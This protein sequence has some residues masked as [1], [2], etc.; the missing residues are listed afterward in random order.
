VPFA[1]LLRDA[2]ESGERQLRII[3]DNRSF[4]GELMGLTKLVER[5]RREP[6]PLQRERR[7]RRPLR[8][9]CRTILPRQVLIKPEL[10]AN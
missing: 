3:Q 2:G 7:V 10:F 9:S 6:D 4:P 1:C 5:A 8:F